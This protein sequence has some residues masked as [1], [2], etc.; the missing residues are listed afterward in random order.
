MLYVSSDR[1][2]CSVRLALK[3]GFSFYKEALKENQVFFETEIL[4][5]VSVTAAPDGY[6]CIA[7]GRNSIKDCLSS[8]RDPDPPALCRL[9]E[10]LR[11]LLEKCIQFHI[12]MYDIIYDYGAV[13]TGENFENFKF[14]YMPG[15]RFAQNEK[16]CGELVKILFLHMYNVLPE[17]EY[18]NISSLVDRLSLAKTHE[19]IFRLLQNIEDHILQYCR[20]K[21][22]NVAERFRGWVRKYMQTEP[23]PHGKKSEIGK[24]VPQKNR[25]AEA[26]PAGI[27]SLQGEAKL[28]GFYMEKTIWE[29]ESTVI[30]IGRDRKWADIYVEDIMVSRH[31]AEI[32]A[33]D[34][35]KIRIK[36]MSLNGTFVGNDYLQKQET[37]K[38]A[39]EEIQL[40]VTEDCVLFVKYKSAAR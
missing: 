33:G 1:N 27:L 18:R 31:H 13:F 23:R 9:A 6:C 40:F 19:E 3:N 16:N 8:G 25:C 39:D 17:E 4:A 35:E 38:T 14:I 34:G 15:A 20:V 32:F 28:S 22:E 36:D 21:K 30:K 11:Q 2:I 26:L 7:K 24:E 37:E 29:K 10:A 12:S 5:S